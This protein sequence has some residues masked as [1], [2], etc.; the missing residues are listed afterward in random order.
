[1]KKYIRIIIYAL[2][3]AAAIL[4]IRKPVT[5]S[6][7]I[8]V[9][10][11]SDYI[12]T[13]TFGDGVSITWIQDNAH[14]RIMPIS[15]FPTADTLLVDSLGLKDGVP[16][17]VSVF[18]IEKEG[19]KMLFDAGL[20]AQDS[21]LQDALSFLGILPESIDYI[22]LTHCHGD[23]IGGMTS[24]D[25]AVFTS[26]EVYLSAEEY[27]QWKDSNDALFDRMRSLYEGRLHTFPFTGEL[28]CG[29]KP[30][31]AVGHTEGHTVYEIGNILVVGDILHGAAL[32]M[33]DTKICARFDQ[34]TELAIRNRKSILEYARMNN[35]TMA[36]MHF[37]AP[38]F[39]GHSETR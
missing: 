28:P 2:A 21:R 6:E 27:D 38:G 23:H 17:T 24:S 16:S 36:G 39:I 15:L 22:F 11:H 5:S 1:M 32:Q 18:L 35:L 33:E 34:D 13:R 12:Q 26:A 10:N 30:I 14:P 20:G 37:P 3:I 4:V 7:P 29:V 8:S 19:K 25:E 9:V 31:S